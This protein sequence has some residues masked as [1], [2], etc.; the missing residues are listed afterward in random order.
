MLSPGTDT[1]T[2]KSAVPQIAV[3]TPINT[4]FTE[5]VDNKLISGGRPIMRWMAI[6]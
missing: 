4:R 6:Q 2:L 5:N 1:S 3:L